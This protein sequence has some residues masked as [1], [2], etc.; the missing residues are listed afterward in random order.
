MF[1]TLPNTNFNFLVTFILSSAK[2]LN[3][4]QSK[5]LLFGK[6]LNNLILDL[7]KLQAFADVNSD[8]IRMALFVFKCP[9][10]ILAEKFIHTHT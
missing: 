3:L 2:A 4:D 7:S 10:N 5:T 8:I 9:E 1:S 6:E